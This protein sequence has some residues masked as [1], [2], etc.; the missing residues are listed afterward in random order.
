[1]N[2]PTPEYAETKAAARNLGRLVKRSQF[3][4]VAAGDRKWAAPGVVLQALAQTPTG[5]AASGIRVGFT[6]SRRVGGAVARN[7]AKRRL[8]AAAA[9]ILPRNGLPNTDY[10]LIA[11]KRTLARPYGDLLT[12]LQSALKK[13]DAWRDA[14]DEKSHALPLPH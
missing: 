6:A 4:A 2:T 12:D 9:E 14:A 11:R 7:R 10:V 1:M 8:R 5:S 13:L 3:L